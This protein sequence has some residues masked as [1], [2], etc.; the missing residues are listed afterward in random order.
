[1]LRIPQLPVPTTAATIAGDLLVAIHRGYLPWGT[2]VPSQTDLMRAYKVATATAASALS[3][4]DAVGLTYT[5]PGKGRF[6]V[7]KP[8][9]FQRHDVLDILDAA[10][11]CRRLAS[12]GGGSA[13]HYI[14]VGGDP[15]W[16]DPHADPEKSMPPRRVDVTALVGVDRH[17]L[18]WI[19]EAFVD[20]ARRI[21]GHGQVDADRHLVASARAILRDGAVRPENQAPIAHMGG[22]EPVWEDVVLRIWPERAEPQPDGPPF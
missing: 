19:S 14:G 7:A 10:M 12:S 15:D 3:K 8:P 2:Q 6:V 11:I 9:L 21:V 13:P 4:L 5:V 1:M 17:L 20:A 16:D 18:R 22:P